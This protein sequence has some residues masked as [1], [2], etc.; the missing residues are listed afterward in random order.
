MEMLSLSI[1]KVIKFQTSK[2]WST[3]DRMA[4][5]ANIIITTTWLLEDTTFLHS[6]SMNNGPVLAHN[7]NNNNSNNNIGLTIIVVHSDS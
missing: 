3:F 6:Y 5:R 2:L 4:R 7:N 1:E